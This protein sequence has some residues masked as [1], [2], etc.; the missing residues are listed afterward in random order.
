[1][2][3]K[4]I[5][6]YISCIFSFPLVNKAKAIN[7]EGTAKGNLLLSSLCVKPLY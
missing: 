3:L 1:M 4:D 7:S 6:F 5:Q 2:Q